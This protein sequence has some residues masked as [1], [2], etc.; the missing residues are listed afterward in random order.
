MPGY[1]THSSL[2]ILFLVPLDILLWRYY[3]LEDVFLFS[4]G[5]IFA[6]YFLSPDMDVF[7]SGPIRRWGPFRFIWLPYTI[8][9]TH[10]GL[11]HVPLLGTLTRVGYLFVL[12]LIISL[13]IFRDYTRV[14]RLVMEYR[15]E[16]LWVLLGMSVADSMHILLDNLH[17]RL[18]RKWR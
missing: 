15:Y 16:I 4:T 18:R 7:R 10:R 5:Y 1:R 12:S 9:F 3:S 14:E 8:F 11:S 17:T 2:N 13:A 6:T